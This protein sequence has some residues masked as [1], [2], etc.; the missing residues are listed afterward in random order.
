MTLLSG[1]WITPE[2]CQFKHIYVFLLRYSGTVI[3]TQD[4]LCSACFRSILTPV[5]V[6]RRYKGR[7]AL[8]A[9][10]NMGERQCLI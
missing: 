8:I 5:G 4:L 2:L 3:Q 10:F 9:P 7:T 1:D 6:S